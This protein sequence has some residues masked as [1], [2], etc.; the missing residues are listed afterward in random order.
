ML[1]VVGRDGEKIPVPSEVE[2]EGG[3]AIRAW[4]EDRQE[5][6]VVAEEESDGD[7]AEDDD[8]ETDE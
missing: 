2:A 8:E 5:P 4:V 7:E 1:Y 3:G 6:E